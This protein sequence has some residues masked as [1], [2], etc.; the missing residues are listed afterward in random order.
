MVEEASSYAEDVGARL[1]QV[2]T[3]QGLSLQDV[4]RISRGKWKAAVVGS[5]ERGD[6]NISASRLCE[7]AEFYS[8]SPADVLPTDDVPRPVERGRGIV[9]D[10]AAV[11]RDPDRWSGLRRYCE[12]IQLQRGDYNRQMLSVRGEDLRAL[13]VIMETNPDALLSDL[14][15]AGIIAQG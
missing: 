2:R 14:R 9:L 4:E 12:S 6:R 5:Y 8:V 11:E 3:Q 7:L 15:A 10:L 1:R 13:A